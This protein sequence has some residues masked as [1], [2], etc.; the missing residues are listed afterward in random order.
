MKPS[1]LVLI[2]GKIVTVD[3]GLTEAQALAIRGDRIAAVGDDRE[4]KAHIGCKTEVLDLDGKLAIPGLIEGHA[5]LVMLG[6]SLQRLNLRKAKSWDEIVDMVRAKAQQAQPGQWITGWGWHQ[7]K[8]TVYPEQSVQG[9]PTHHALSEVSPDNPVLLTHGSGHMGV[10]NA[11]AMA[12]A[13]IGASSPDPPGGQILRTPT[14]EPSGIFIETAKNLIQGKLDE[15]CRQRSATQIKEDERAVVKLAV[16]DCLSKG[17]TS[18]QD[19]G[20]TFETIAL[21]RALVRDGELGI[22]LWAMVNE[23]NERLENQL[24][25]HVVTGMGGNRLTVRAV[26]R[27]IDGAMG[28]HSAW[29]LEPYADL[30]GKT[31]FSSLVTGSY[32]DLPEDANEQPDFP[33]RYITQTARIAIQKGVQLCTHAIGD[34]ACREVLD[35]YER[36]FRAHPQKNDLRWRVEHASV[37]SPADIPR[38]GQL[39]VIPSIQAISVATDGPWMIERVGEHRARER[40][41]TFQKLLQ[42]GALL[43]NGTDAPVEDVDPLPCFRASIAC[44]LPDGTVYWP[45]QR[46]TREQALRSYTINAAYAAFEERIKGSLTPGKLADIV[47]L[48]DDIM[49]IPEEAIADAR[50]LYTIVGGQVAYEG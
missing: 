45:D 50:V 18:F 42:S 23:S 17:I 20:V 4:I 48:S 39:G 15:A 26:K 36:T 31:G 11:R 32:G 21:F 43:V 40:L 33:A 13:G 1:D 8:W 9:L 38:F 34:R 28:A 25:D 12:L 30:P 22:R 44:R 2:N 19:A 24:S 16:R 35:I 47:V 6:Q 3:D 29:M 10:A 46:L 14:G 41:F 49:T 7:E 37:L 5:H 27:L